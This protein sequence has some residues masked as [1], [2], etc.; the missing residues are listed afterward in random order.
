MLKGS[1]E[2]NFE[3]WNIMGIVVG[4]GS[5]NPSI[6]NTYE[7]QVQYLRDFLTTRWHYMDTRLNEEY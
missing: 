6:Y 7:K 4:A 1:Q 2:Q 5:V 3:V